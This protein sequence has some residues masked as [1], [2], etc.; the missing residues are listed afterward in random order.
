M[1]KTLLGAVSAT[2]VFVSMPAVAQDT[3]APAAQNPSQQAVSTDGDIV[4]TG[5]RQSLER[6]AEIKRN[7]TQVV[8]SIVAT[9]I[10]KLPDPT[11]AAALQRVP[12]IQVQNDRNNELSTVRIRGLTDIWTTVNGREVVTTTGRGFDLQ[13]VPAEALA[14]IDA[15][16]SQTADQIEGGVAGA[17]DLRLNR[18]FAFRDPTFV[19][20]ARQ[21]YATI[22]DASNPQLG[23]LAAA[24]T[25]TS[26][27][28][29]GALVNVPGRRPRISA[30]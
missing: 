7:A 24:K 3:E 8:D 29:I 25:D 6:A 21:N 19:L 2:A 17:L 1:R 11:V 12:G 10:G 22:A 20:T 23:A 9:D 4:V 27:G 16:K 5:V 14:R 26:I 30:A 15:F 18:P 28:E 13:D